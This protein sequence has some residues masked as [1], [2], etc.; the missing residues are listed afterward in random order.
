[1]FGF[2]KGRL[3]PSLTHWMLSDSIQALGGWRAGGQEWREAP[4][5]AW[6]GRGECPQEKS[7]RGGM[8]PELLDVALDL[9]CCLPHSLPVSPPHTHC[10]VVWDGVNGSL[11]LPLGPTPDLGRRQKGAP[12]LLGQQGLPS[13]AWLWPSHRALT[14]TQWLGRHHPFHSLGGDD[15]PVG[16]APGP[17]RAGPP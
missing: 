1:M 7:P 10:Q 4:G 16:A 14:P 2:C 8:S 9:G 13:P 3:F 12:G 11:P 5:T 17:S 6:R 15:G